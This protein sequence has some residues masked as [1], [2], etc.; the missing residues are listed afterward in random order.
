MYFI[1]TTGMLTLKLN[2]I[3]WFYLIF[4]SLLDP[5]LFTLLKRR[6]IDHK[7]DKHAN[8]LNVMYA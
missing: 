4:P 7:T 5:N 2:K 1:K 8:K 3:I 6:W